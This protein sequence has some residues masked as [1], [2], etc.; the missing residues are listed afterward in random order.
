[1]LRQKLPQYCQFPSSCCPN[2]L[3]ILYGTWLAKLKIGKVGSIRM[4]VLFNTLIILALSGLSGAQTWPSG[5]ISDPDAGLPCPPAGTLSL[6]VSSAM[7]SNEVWSDNR[8]KFSICMAL[9]RGLGI[10]AASS[11][12]DISGHGAYQRGI[13]DTRVGLSY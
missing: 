7:L 9:G 6:R 3:I 2:I 8:S 5:A 4:R 10:S 13:E 11:F 12:R 1:M